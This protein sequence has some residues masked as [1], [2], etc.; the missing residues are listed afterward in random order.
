[1]KIPKPRQTKNGRWFIQ[2]CVKGER[3]SKTFD[4]REEAI[5]WATTYKTTFSK[6]I[7]SKTEYD[8]ILRKIANDDNPR[9][10]VKEENLLSVA[11][12]IKKVDKMDGVE[13]EQYCSSLFL[14]SGFFNGAYFYQTKTTGDYGA[15]IIINCLDG[16]SVS[17]QC[18]RMNS[19]VRVDAIQE[20]VASKAY[21]HTDIAAVI[22][23][24]AFTPQ[25]KELA[26]ENNVFLFDRAHLIK[27]I[28][29]KIEAIN[30]IQKTRQWESLIKELEK[31][32]KK[33]YDI[34]KKPKKE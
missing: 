28:E 14:L 16:L 7:R 9:I 4:T 20:V 25:A 30:A 11:D 10:T 8:K 15:D 26:R 33:R 34:E 6:T 24:A 23:N 31:R 21:Y 2:L 12:E 27:M 1:M 3:P 29:M 13:F 32:P 19:N 5:Q 17:I 22:T 18:K